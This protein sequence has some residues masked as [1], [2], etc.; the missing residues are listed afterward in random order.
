MWIELLIACLAA[1]AHSGKL[2]KA[3]FNYKY[4]GKYCGKY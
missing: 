4:C 1:V 3:F 2:H